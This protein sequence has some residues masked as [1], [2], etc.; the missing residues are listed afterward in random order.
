MPDISEIIAKA[1]PRETTVPVYMDGSAAAEVEEL[2][3]QLA[4]LSDTWQPDSLAATDPTLDLA[5]RIQAARERMQESRADFRLRA[6]GD[7]AWSDLVA[8]HPSSNPQQLWDPAT[9]PKALLSVCCQ[10][11]TMTVEQVADLFEVINE[12]QREELINAAIGVNQE[13][14]SIPFSV[15]A[16]AILSSLTDEK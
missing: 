16:S 2:E 8:A 4:D 10:G 9:F 5:K 12:G 14:T 15:N 13:A 1:R 6:L 3:R 7:K 11:P